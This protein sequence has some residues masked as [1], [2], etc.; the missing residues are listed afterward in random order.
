MGLSIYQVFYFIRFEKY[1]A[2]YLLG[3]VIEILLIII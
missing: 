2:G 3:K 1:F